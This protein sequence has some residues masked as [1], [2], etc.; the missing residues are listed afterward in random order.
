MS[1]IINHSMIVTLF[2]ILSS[3]TKGEERGINNPSTS[4]NKFNISSPFVV[5]S[6]FEENGCEVD[7]MMYT[8]NQLGICTTISESSSSYYDIK[9][10]K[11]VMY[12]CG[13]ANCGKLNE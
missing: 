9:E 12:F 1:H 2:L 13:D 7:I 3:P 5:T 4:N 6:V 8:I 10:E 11:V